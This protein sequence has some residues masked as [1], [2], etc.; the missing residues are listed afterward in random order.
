MT[1]V[2]ANRKQHKEQLNN[3][4]LLSHSLPLEEMLW[5]SLGSEQHCQSS[6]KAGLAW[7]EQQPLLWR[8]GFDQLQALMLDESQKNKKKIIFCDFFE[9]GMT[10]TRRLDAGMAWLFKGLEMETQIL[11][12]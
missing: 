11:S 1:K 8:I 10:S 4:P 3:L 5:M 12:S 9:C 7:L 6:R 2:I